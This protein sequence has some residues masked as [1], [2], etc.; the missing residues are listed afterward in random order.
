MQLLIHTFKSSNE[1]RI[2]HIIEELYNCV[3]ELNTALSL[4]E[5]KEYVKQGE[6]V[7]DIPSCANSNNLSCNRL[8]TLWLCWVGLDSENNF[9]V[10]EFRQL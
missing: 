10:L 9:P 7:W 6:Q 3:T 2:Y 1:P 4:L 5:I 8:S